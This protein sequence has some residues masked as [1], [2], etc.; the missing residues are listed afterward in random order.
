MIWLGAVI[1]T[2]GCL[3][4]TALRW[5]S[6]GYARIAL[7]GLFAVL[8]SL[9]W[10]S[11]V[12]LRGRPRPVQQAWVEAHAQQQDVLVVG[13]L[14]REGVAIYL[15]LLPKDA[16]EP[17]FY[18]MDY[19]K[20][21]AESLQQARREA[22]RGEAEGGQGELRMRRP[23]DKSLSEDKNRFYAPPQPKMQIKPP[24]PPVP[25]HERI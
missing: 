20:E 18:V 23:F 7:A 21:A 2:S 3:C 15:W 6:S 4:L 11:A 16:P 8:L 1:V 19:S 24:A 12:D 9:F 25:R 17:R 10:L 13:S 22:R 5:T 14:I